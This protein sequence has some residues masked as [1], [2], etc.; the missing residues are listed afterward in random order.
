MS[1][2]NPTNKDLLKEIKQINGNIANHHE[3]IKTLE[4]WKI[5]T[6]AAKSAIDQYKQEHRRNGNGVTLPR[7]VMKLIMWLALGVVL[8][9]GGKEFIQWDLETY[10]ARKAR[11]LARETESL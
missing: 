3:R 5:A 9:L 6:D 2:Q 8:A 7:E 4:A 10:L 1:N 11:M